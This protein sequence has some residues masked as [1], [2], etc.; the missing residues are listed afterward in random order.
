MRKRQRRSSLAVALLDLLAV[1]HDTV[2]ICFQV[3]QVQSVN[4]ASSSAIHPSVV[5]N[6]IF[7]TFDAEIYE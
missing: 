1:L 7:E 2:I 3:C 5:A 4:S 6:G